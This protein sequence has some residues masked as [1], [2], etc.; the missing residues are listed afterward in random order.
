MAATS[1]PA[2]PLSGV[3]ESLSLLERI[4]SSPQFRS[5]PQLQA[6][7]RFL[8]MAKIEGR[9]DELKEYTLGC[10]VFRRG[11]AYD[12]RHDSIV[13]V[14]A[15]M[16]RKRLAA[17]FES[18]GKD[19]PLRFELP[20]GGYVLELVDTTVEATRPDSVH[21]EPPRKVRYFLL[22]GLLMVTSVFG[23]WRIAKTTDGDSHLI[24]LKRN[25]SIPIA[26]IVDG[27]RALPA[28][29][30]EVLDGS[31][32]VLLAFG[33]PQFFTA[34]KVYV[35]DVNVNGSDE[36]STDERLHSLSNKLGIFL[37]PAPD[38]YTG[39]GELVGT[40]KITQF[41]TLNGVLADVR[42]AQL[43][44]KDQIRDTN[45]I[46]IS[47]YRF[48][49]ALNLLDLPTAF[50][51]DYLSQNGGFRIMDRKSGEREF[52]N[53]RSSGRVGISYAVL[54]YWRNA[55]PAHRILSVS[56][57]DSWATQGAA[58][59]LA[60]PDALNDINALLKDQ[61]ISK[62]K[63]MEFLLEIEGSNSR[64]LTSRIVTHRVHF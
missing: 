46:L 58:E 2:A 61:P 15:S 4:L 1:A 16:L 35:R 3:S 5:S 30:G 27:T 37:R 33:C 34:G 6:L 29:W 60:N 55:K 47:S 22:T 36:S 57:I 26:E 43:I 17:Y 9:E 63:G 23:G 54:S 13:R 14:Q 62:A 7:L 39:V 41:L 19:E 49:T 11:K 28:I 18:E 48:H 25:A 40:Q 32:R 12:P 45:L 20:K 50:Q 44:T 51:S 24:R 10:E 21:A 8:V 56:G 59:F 31:H 42:N 64:P 38:T 52:Y 53:V